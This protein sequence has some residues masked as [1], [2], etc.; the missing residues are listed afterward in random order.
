[1]PTKDITTSVRRAL[2]AIGVFILTATPPAFAH[3]AFAA[4][5]DANKKVTFEG[6]LTKVAWFNPHGWIY[7]DVVDAGTTTNWS[8]EF[9][10]PTSLLRKGLRR[11]DFQPGTRLTVKGYRARSGKPVANASNVTLP[12]GRSLFAGSANSPDGER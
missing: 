7:I 11:T 4:E 3:H 6:E 10:S 1:M 8:I 5:F 12:D 2:A 9:G